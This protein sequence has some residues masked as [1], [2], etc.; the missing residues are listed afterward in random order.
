[1]KVLIS[2][3]GIVEWT[4]DSDA[5]RRARCLDFST[6]SGDY[7]PWFEGDVWEAMDICN[8]LPGAPACPMRERCLRRALIN[9]ERWGVWG[10]MLHNDR[11]KL[12]DKYPDQPEKWTWHPPSI[13]RPKPVPQD[14]GA[15]LASRPC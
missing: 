1:M 2:R 9:N 14:P 5:G 6:P 15:P 13:K 12:K 7:D 3:D 8:G 11:K 10:G 4:G